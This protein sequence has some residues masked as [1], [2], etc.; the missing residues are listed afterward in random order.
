M[1]AQWNDEMALVGF[2]VA[3]DDAI[4][5]AKGGRPML[6]NVNNYTGSAIVPSL[7]PSLPGVHLT[8]SQR[9]GDEMRDRYLEHLRER[10]AGG[11]IDSAEHNARQDIA[12][13]AKTEEELTFLLRDLPSLSPPVAPVV[14]AAPKNDYYPGTNI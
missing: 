13:K 8:A 4:S 9:I 10:F 11:Y 2:R 7:A 12:M 5:K 1:E 14:K 3:F 6:I